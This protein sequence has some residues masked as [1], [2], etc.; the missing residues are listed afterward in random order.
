[1]NSEKPQT[2]FGR[3]VAFVLTLLF[4]IFLS[5]FFLHTSFDPVFLGKYNVRYLTFLTILFIVLLPGFYFVI[6]FLFSSSEL[7]GSGGRRIIVTSRQKITATIFLSLIGYLV[8]NFAIQ[9][10]MAGMVATFDA[11][12]FHPYLQNIPRPFDAGQ[13]VNRWGFKGDEIEV[14][15]LPNT[16]RV[17]VFGGSTV[18]CGTVPF[19]DTHVRLLEKHL[20][21]AYPKHRIEVQNLGAEWHSTEH[22]TIKLLFLAQ[23]FNP[24]LVVIYH[25][26]NDVVRSFEPDLFGN[27][28][29]RSD[30]QH[31]L[32][33]V[34]N[35]V[36]PVRG[37]MNGITTFGG[38]WCSDFRSDQVR[39]HGPEGKGLRHAITMFFPRST[40]VEIEKWNSL[41]AFERN[42]RDFVSIAQ[43]K[44]INVLLATQPSLY[45][46]DLS[47]RD[48]EVLTF[49]TS[50][51]FRRQRA[52]LA[53]MVDGM[54]QFNQRTRQIAADTKVRFVDLEQKMPKTTDFMYDD[55]H[56]T[57]AGNALIARTFADDII[58]WGIVHQTLAPSESAAASPPAAGQ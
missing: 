15:K 21:A 56:Y 52:S 30:Y 38:H 1:M 31:Y 34:A 54:H 46:A 22:D 6:R 12:S 36:H 24:D 4:G 11:H 50:H 51:Q 5:G 20:Q 48:Q 25:G 14:K 26:I 55:V 29:Y 27:G 19:E 53:S 3:R 13:H 41:P 47:P 9:M 16:F 44:K 40:P 58:S 23:D 57:R 43:A 35:M 17:F 32:G 28:P 33:A 8:G 45:R 42:L 10:V 18:H 39:V 37:L 2:N 49:P 7:R